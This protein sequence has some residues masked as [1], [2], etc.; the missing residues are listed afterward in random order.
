MLQQILA[1]MYIDP[2]LL[3]ELDNEQKQILFCKMREEQVRQW[4][5]HE[6][7]LETKI[8]SKPK[9]PPKPGSKRVTFML[10]KDGNPWTWIMGEHSDDKSIDVILDNEARKEALLQAE[11]EAE[12][13][14]R[15][16]EQNINNSIAQ[17]AKSPTIEETVK[18]TQ[19]AVR[20]ICS[21]LNAHDKTASNWQNR[22]SLDFNEHRVNEIYASIRETQRK[23]DELSEIVRKEE[24]ERWKE[25]EIKAKEAER[26]IRELARQAREEHKKVS[27]NDQTA[28]E[29][30]NNFITSSLNDEL[31][32]TPPPK[33]KRSA[34]FVINN[35]QRNQQNKPPSQDSIME[36]FESEELPH[37]PEL[38]LS[39]PN[40]Y[41]WFHGMIS[42]HEAE[43]RL[44]H[45][46]E[47]SFLVRLSER[48]WGYAISYRTKERC[49]HFLIEASGSHYQ[50]FGTGHLAHNSLQNLINYHKKR[51]LTI[52]GQEYLLLPRPIVS[53]SPECSSAEVEHQLT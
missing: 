31:K 19:F 11:K 33:H 21:E 28:A 45:A 23:A 44:L 26:Q 40:A 20:D 46:D 37:C 24:E 1:D 14:R 13:L 25:R 9:I 15:N 34:A 41:P 39:S 2:Q 30:E 36:W 32:A 47:G 51:P 42:R 27:Q 52:T 17:N 4:K 53:L 22:K 38:D 29:S 18:S 16:N 6:E 35:K 12:V 10:G 7:E 5:S 43:T 8:T 50:F 3:A 48:I 49:K